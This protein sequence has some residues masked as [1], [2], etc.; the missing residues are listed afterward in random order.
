MNNVYSEFPNWMNI[1]FLIVSPTD[2]IYFWRNFIVM[3]MYAHCTTH[4]HCNEKASD[5]DRL[6]YNTNK[7]LHFNLFRPSIYR[8]IEIVVRIQSNSMIDDINVHPK[9]R[10]KIFHRNST[11]YYKVFPNRSNQRFDDS[12][13]RHCTSNHL[14]FCILLEFSSY[15]KSCMYKFRSKNRMRFQFK[16][17]HKIENTT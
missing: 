6:G 13:S 1:F 15:W 12:C 7:Y 14:I 2:I 8:D 5:C 16:K 9:I 10:F 3:S 4:C 11:I 17:P